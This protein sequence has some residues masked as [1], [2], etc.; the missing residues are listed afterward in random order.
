MTLPCPKQ[1][2]CL[3]HNQL[4]EI[5]RKDELPRKSKRVDEVAVVVSGSQHCC[6]KMKKRTNEE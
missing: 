3:Q 2:L 4:L 1:R 5:E 6:T